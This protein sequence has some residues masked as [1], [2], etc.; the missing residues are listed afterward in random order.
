MEVHRLLYL[1]RPEAKW[2]LNFILMIKYPIGCQI[3]P[4]FASF[5]RDMKRLDIEEGQ[6]PM[7]TV[8][9]RREDAARD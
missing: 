2:G 5:L 7:E 3:G 4:G 1:V 9:K 6:N 8:G